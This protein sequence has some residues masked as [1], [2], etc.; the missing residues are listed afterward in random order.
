MKYT[1]HARKLKSRVIF[2]CTTYLSD[3]WSNAS[4]YK[5]QSLFYCYDTKKYDVP[6][7]PLPFTNL[8][9]IFEQFGG[10]K[11]DLNDNCNNLN[12]SVNKI[13][14]F[15]SKHIMYILKTEDDKK[16]HSQGRKIFTSWEKILW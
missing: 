5:N 14:N 12:H 7:L 2:L 9:R 16:R 6:V 1:G 15:K 13:F 8:E 11:S 10:S 4:I 3:L